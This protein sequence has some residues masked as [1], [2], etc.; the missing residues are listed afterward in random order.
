MVRSVSQPEGGI[1]RHRD[2]HIAPL[3]GD[4]PHPFIIQRV[5]LA[6]FQRYR[7]NGHYLT[8][9]TF[10]FGKEMGKFQQLPAS[11]FVPFR[12]RGRLDTQ[13]ETSGR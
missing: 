11:D 12:L 7:G 10:H 1:D 9:N 6:S 13:N 5:V 2:C 3:T 8:K 4:D